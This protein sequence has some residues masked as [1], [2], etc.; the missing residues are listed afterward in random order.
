L[1]II[2]LPCNQFG[3]QEP[4]GNAEEILNGVKWVR[5]GKGFVP[6]FNLTQRVEVNGE[7]Q[8]PLY[9]FLKRSC[10]STREGFSGKNRLYYEPLHVRDI[11]WNWEKFLIHP[12]FGT[13]LRRYDP[14]FDPNDMVQDIQSLL[15]EVGLRSR[16]HWSVYGAIPSEP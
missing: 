12:F 14:S 7:N 9:S 4:G 11:R 10:P 3:L 15:E 2:G 8:L 5:P 16:A 1:E 13:P 6:K